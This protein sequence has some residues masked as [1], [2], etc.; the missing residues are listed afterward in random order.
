M[1]VRPSPNHADFS[2]RSAAWILLA[3]VFFYHAAG[4]SAFFLIDRRPANYNELS[5]VI[6]AIEYLNRLVDEK[7]PYAASLHA[8]T[9]YPPIGAVASLAYAVGGRHHLSARFSQLLFSLILSASVYLLGRALFDRRTGVLAVFLLLTS[10]AA[11]DLSRQY[12]LEWPL[13]AIAAL[14]AYCLWRS[15]GFAERRWSL[16]AGL[17]VGLAALC[18]QT[19]FLFLAGP[20]LFVAAAAWQKSRPPES[21][22]ETGAPKNRRHIWWWIVFAASWAMAAALYSPAHREAID[23]WYRASTPWILPWGWAFFL[24]TGGCFTGVLLLFRW[25][26][27]PWR[28]ALAAGL[29]TIGLAGIWYFPIGLM[30]FLTYYQQMRFNAEVEH[31]S[32][33]VMMKFYASYL[34]PYYLGPTLALVLPPVLL[35][36]GYQL[37]RPKKEISAKQPAAPWLF[38][39]VWAAIPVAVLP[40]ISIQNEMNLVPALPPVYLAIAA[41]LTLPWRRNAGFG[42]RLVFS[43]GSLAAI[44][45]GLLTTGLFPGAGGFRP[46]PFGLSD[47][48]ANRLTPWKFSYEN[49]LVPRPESWHEEDIAQAI[50]QAGLGPKPRLLM[51][52]ENFYYNGNTFYYLFKLRHRELTVETQWWDDHDW[53]A[54]DPDGRP[55]LDSFDVIFYRRPWKAIYEQ[56]IQAGEK[57]NLWRTYA[58]LD[59]PPPD[60]ALH[61]RPGE[62]WP[63]PDGSTAYLLYRQR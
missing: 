50:L 17:A 8:F 4:N 46:L 26:A 3:V 15:D 53:L 37:F 21:A 20:V 43:L 54:A 47:G 39:T 34:E 51:M 2:S 56:K 12:L 16:T 55:R 38:L 29:A 62:S 61:F 19:F 27:K 41:L 30:N 31:F 35:L 48:L 6:G 25:R 52:D 9:G 11:C 49:Y 18:K 42:W 59:D 33:W 28:N 57:I 14:A 22:T 7:D 44:F 60:F 36:A 24:V 10:P 1:A 40:F 45:G 63:F 13:T 5:H 23:N 32:P 58:Y